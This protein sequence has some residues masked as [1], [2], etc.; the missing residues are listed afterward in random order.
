MFLKDLTSA[1]VDDM[2]LQVEGLF[3]ERSILKPVS[4][5]ELSIHARLISV[6]ETT[7]NV[8]FEGFSG[9]STFSLQPYKNNSP[10]S[11]RN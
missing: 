7:V 4:F 9:G 2:T 11:K 6:C 8:R 3:C 5:A 1:A 10:D